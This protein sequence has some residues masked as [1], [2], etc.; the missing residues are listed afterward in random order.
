MKIEDKNSL[1]FVTDV[2]DDE[3]KAIDSLLSI[4]ADNYWFKKKGKFTNWD[5]IYHFYNKKHNC[6]PA[7]FIELFKSKYQNIQ[8]IDN[9]VAPKTDRSKIL[10]SLRGYQ[11]DAV[12]A[13]LDKR[14]GLIELPT[15]SGKT[16]VISGL[17]SV[18]RDNVI[19]IV[20]NKNL[21]YQ[22]IDVLKKNLN[23]DIGIC[24]DG[25]L[26][27]KRITV[28][29]YKSVAKLKKKDLD[30]F[31]SFIVD[32][33]HHSSA[34]TIFKLLLKSNAYYRFGVS[35]D[36]LDQHKVKQ[37]SKYKRARVVGSIGPVIFKDKPKDVLATA[38]IKVIELDEEVTDIPYDQAYCK[39]L[40][41]NQNLTDKVLELCENHKNDAILILV[42]HIHHG[43]AISKQLKLSHYWLHGSLDSK[44]INAK[45]AEFN[46]GKAN[47]ILGSTIF[48]EGVDM[49]GIDVLINA[50]GDVAATKQRV[51]RGLRKKVN[52]PNE[53]II[54]D[55]HIKG[56]NFT[57]SHFK[58]RKRIYL[59][60]GH[61]IE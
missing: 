11:K 22:T 14:R 57:E 32:E 15:G 41:N 1:A 20:P 49:P 38:K 34:N 47:I 33:A 2:T 42:K 52:K 39:Y 55:F 46:A 17:C 45:I 31:T 30:L 36:V 6:F 44:F 8:Y 25:N 16:F 40:C 48:N 29:I 35:A 9:N 61:T 59:H 56:P 10:D 18:I 58:K 27:L 5:G 51:G 50:A 43:D 7:G 12:L 4:K 19:I 23:E 28:G 37:D 26:K 54:Y 24:G 3:I 21:L 13:A 60:E 53:V